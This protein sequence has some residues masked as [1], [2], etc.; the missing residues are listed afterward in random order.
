MADSI[1]TLQDVAAKAGVSISTASRALNGLKVSKVNGENVRKAAELLGYVANEGARSLRGVRTMTMGVVFNELNDPLGF[2]LLEALTTAVEEHGYSLFISVARGQ[3]ERYDLLTHRFLERRVDALFCASAAGEGAALERF[4]N[5][6]IPAVA[7]FSHSGGYER[8]PLISPGIEQAAVEM[9]ERLKALGHVSLGIVRPALR[10]AP[11]EEVI[12]VARAGGLTVRSYTPPERSLDAI[13]CLNNLLSEADGP[14]V[15]VGRQGDVVR[16]LEAADEL[17]VHV[18]HD[19]SL[20]AIRDR[21]QQMVP[22]RV[23]LSMIH[24]NP[25][26]VGKIAADLVVDS[27][28]GRALTDS[29]VEMGAWIERGSTGPA[30]TP[31]APVIRTLARSRAS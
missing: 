11:V 15:I 25:G 6:G 9:I 12:R 31:Q 26:K 7:L 23:P 30:R 1:T 3:E 28:T 29:V 27:L 24:L 19:L 18:P 21:S 20:V 13:T 8:L 16:L 10:S 22:T 17:H 4:A 5:A 14:T 2:E